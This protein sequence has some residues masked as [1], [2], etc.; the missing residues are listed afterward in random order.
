MPLL[1]TQNQENPETSWPSLYARAANMQ[2]WAFTIFA[3]ACDSP[4]GR[5]NIHNI[6]QKN[7]Q[8]EKDP[9]VSE[10]VF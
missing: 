10:R 5:K 9:P 8:K 1:S 4:V 3:A 7:Y 2:A 6:S